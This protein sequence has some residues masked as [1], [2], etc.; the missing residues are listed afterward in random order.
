VS[1]F[2]TTHQ[3]RPLS[4]INGEEQSKVVNVC[5]ESKVKKHAKIKAIKLMQKQHYIR[6]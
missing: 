6:L 1:S 2:L 4:A 3:S 5:I